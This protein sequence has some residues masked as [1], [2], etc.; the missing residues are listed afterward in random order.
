MRTVNI[1][2]NDEAGFDCTWFSIEPTNDLG[3][4]IDSFYSPEEV[5][6]YC[7]EN[8]LKIVKI[9]SSISN[10]NPNY[11]EAIDKFSIMSQVF[12]I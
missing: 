4:W 7:E 9:Y 6:K 2:L 1:H 8:D 11:S 5:K 3:N 12:A 10:R